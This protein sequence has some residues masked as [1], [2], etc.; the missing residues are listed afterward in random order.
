MGNKNNVQRFST[1]DGQFDVGF[2][3]CIITRYEQVQDRVITERSS[4]SNDDRR[5]RYPEK[6]RGN[7]RTS[8]ERRGGYDD[9]EGRQ[10]GGQWELVGEG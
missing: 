8:R 6:G 10:T 4:R 2:A 9:D 1:R 7:P 5:S 3:R